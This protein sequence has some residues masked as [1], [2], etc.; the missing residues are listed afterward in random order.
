MLYGRAMA[1]GDCESG[2][3]AAAAADGI[4]LVRGR[5]PWLNQRGHLGLPAEL[6]DVASTLEAIFLA[7]DGDLAAQASKRTTPL[8]GDSVHPPT[9]TLIEVDEHQ[10][11]RSHRLTS[12]DRYPVNTPLGFDRER[13]RALCRSESPR[14][15][16]Y[17]ASKAAVAFGAGGRQRQRAYFDAVRDLATPAMGRPPLVRVDAVDRDGGAA[18]AR[19]AA[20]LEHLRR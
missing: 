5:E 4:H 18:Y 2:F 6:V 13:Y 14:A 8:P 10:H 17:F 19:A 11:F 3:A 7:L 9:G 20:S 15:D 12:L 1:R 16:R